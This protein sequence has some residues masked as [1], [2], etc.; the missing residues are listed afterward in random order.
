MGIFR[1]E[2]KICTSEVKKL[3]SRNVENSLQ[4]VKNLHR[5]NPYNNLDFSK[6]KSEY[7]IFQNVLLMDE[8]VANLKE[9]IMNN[10][11]NYIE[12]LLTYI[13]SLGKNYK[14]HRAT[15]LSLITRIAMLYENHALRKILVKHFDR[16]FNVY[17]T[18]QQ[19]LEKQIQYFEQEIESCH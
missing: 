10:F 15:N 6:G 18:E 12:R 2:C 8:E 19:D 7:V 16:L 3:H 5:S 4:K 17:D 11:E 13:Q 9:I 14:D 1:F